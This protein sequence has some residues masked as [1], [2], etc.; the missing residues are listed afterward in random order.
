MLFLPA[1][2]PCSSPAQCTVPRSVKLTRTLAP[3]NQVL[4]PQLNTSNNNSGSPNNNKSNTLS[5]AP[6]MKG[7]CRGVGNWLYHLGLVAIE[8]ILSRIFRY[9]TWLRG[10]SVRVNLAPSGS[11]VRLYLRFHNIYQEARGRGGV[12]LG[13]VDQHGTLLSC[14]SSLPS[15]KLSH[16]LDSRSFP[17]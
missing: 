10:T 1:K 2:H 6:R 8:G 16:H 4:V 3:R 12:Y 13:C 11:E 15:H 14:H 7:C 9:G 5:Y 17:S